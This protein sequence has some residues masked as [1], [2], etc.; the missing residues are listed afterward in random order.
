MV[1]GRQG[2]GRGGDGVGVARGG[3]EVRGLVVVRQR[4][5]VGNWVGVDGGGGGGAVGVATRW[6][7]W[8]WRGG[9]FDTRDLIR[10]GVGVTHGDPRFSTLGHLTT[11]AGDTRRNDTHTREVQWRGGGGGGS[12]DGDGGGRGRWWLGGRGGDGVNVAR[13]GDEVRGSMVAWV[14]AQIRRI[15]LDGYGIDMS[16]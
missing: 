13:G 16:S 9:R 15:F 14:G 5:R 8:W 1:A 2:G 12:R 10:H 3:D 4:V 11:G 7:V 6:G